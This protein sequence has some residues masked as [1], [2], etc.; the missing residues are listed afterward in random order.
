MKRGKETWWVETK[1]ND[2]SW[3]KP[4]VGEVWW[5]G[6]DPESYIVFLAGNE[7]ET[8][9]PWVRLVAPV[10]PHEP[11]QVA[12]TREEFETMWEALSTRG[13]EAPSFSWLDAL[14]ARV[15]AQVAAQEREPWE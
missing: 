8:Y 15:D 11:G 7:C 9:R 6:D 1:L 13:A 2:G 5:N 4:Q 3:D 14:K 10:I 12:I